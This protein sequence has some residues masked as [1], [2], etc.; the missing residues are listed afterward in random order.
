MI[1]GNGALKARKRA[2]L[3]DRAARMG[4]IGGFHQMPDRGGIRT[5]ERH[6]LFHRRSHPLMSVLFDQA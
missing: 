2:Q 4:Q 3:D 1:T 6:C 5:A